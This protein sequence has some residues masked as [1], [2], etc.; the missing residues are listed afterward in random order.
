[1]SKS[2]ISLASVAAMALVAGLSTGSAVASESAAGG[3]EKAKQV[4]APTI[5]SNG[6]GKA[7]AWDRNGDGK[8]DAWDRDGDGKP[9]AHDDNGDG[10]PDTPKPATR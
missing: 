8:A 1:M 7:D 3:G 6:D 9:D 5:D 4:P 2:R 10:Q